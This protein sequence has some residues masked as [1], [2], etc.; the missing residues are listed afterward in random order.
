MHQTLPLLFAMVF[1]ACNSYT[2][3]ENQTEPAAVIQDE[4]HVFIE[5]RT[6]KKW[7]VTHAVNRYDF[8]AD[9]FQYGL[10]PQTILPILNPT[11][12]IKGDSAFPADDAFLLIMG[13]K[14]ANDI[15]AYGVG[16]LSRFEVADDFFGEVPIA[17]AY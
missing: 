12:S 15:R 13:V 10:G 1:L 17:V 6:G 7:D 11:F 8:K 3:P 2:E 5:D 4:E 9:Q 16:A 14:F